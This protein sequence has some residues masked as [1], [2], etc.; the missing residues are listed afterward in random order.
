MKRFFSFFLS[1]TLLSNIPLQASL[2][3]T[4][5]LDEPPLDKHRLCLENMV[6]VARWYCP[7]V[8]V[9]IARTYQELCAE[10][11]NTPFGNQDYLGFVWDAQTNTAQYQDQMLAVLNL[12]TYYFSNSSMTTIPFDH[13]H[14]SEHKFILSPGYSHQRIDALQQSFLERVHMLS[15]A[16]Q[17]LI[18]IADVGAGHGYVSRNALI[19]GSKHAASS[20]GNTKPLRG[21]R[22]CAIEQHIPLMKT[23]EGHGPLM[24]AFK[25]AKEIS[26]HFNQT[27]ALAKDYFS[28]ISGDACATLNNT[29]FQNF[30]D[31]LYLG[32]MLHYCTPEKAQTLGRRLFGAAKEGAFVYASVHTD[33][34]FPSIENDRVFECYKTQR[35]QG[36]KFPG[37]M[38][39]NALA[40]IKGQHAQDNIFTEAW[41]LDE[42]TDADSPAK[43]KAGWHKDSSHRTVT[44]AFGD[45]FWS[46]SHQSYQIYD[47]FS[48]KAFFER[49]GFVIED[50]FFLNKYEKRL[51]IGSI[52]TGDGRF[53]SANDTRSAPRVC[54][55]A[56]KPKS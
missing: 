19:A 29:T 43:Q 44:K 34:F 1:I 27:N 40:K 13:T 8:G 24:F 25:Q 21:A 36:K 32:N 26:T 3:T 18:Q 37:W 28:V 31:L 11:Q 33:L 54:V 16:S 42:E 20:R 35:D 39:L 2:P 5:T 22:V 4:E 6:N 45:N 17:T 10:K 9:I 52:G 12:N 46:M 48:L 50:V 53:T 55:I 51:N 38:M 23:T 7:E 15:N 56:R 41:P 47:A 14:Q 49:S 30:F